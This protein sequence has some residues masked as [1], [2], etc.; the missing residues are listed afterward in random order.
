MGAKTYLDQFKMAK[1]RISHICKRETFHYQDIIKN[2]CKKIAVIFLGIK[3]KSRKLTY[4]ISIWGN[5]PINLR[6]IECIDV[7]SRQ[8]HL[9]SFGIENSKLGSE[10]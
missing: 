9:Y 3:G 6:H 7:S 10:Y 5:E 8:H 4:T 2:Y 1:N